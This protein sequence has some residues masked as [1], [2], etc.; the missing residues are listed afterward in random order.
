VKLVSNSVDIGYYVV[1]RIPTVVNLDFLDSEPLYFH[2]SSFSVILK[3][4]SGHRSRHTTR[5]SQKINSV[6]DNLIVVPIDV[7]NLRIT[8]L[9]NRNYV[10]VRKK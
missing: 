8:R 7:Y 10:T 2:S 9:I 6:T 3:R 1:P 4:L 5:T